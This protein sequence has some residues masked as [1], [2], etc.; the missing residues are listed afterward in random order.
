LTL[1][2]TFNTSEICGFFGRGRNVSEGFNPFIDGICGIG[3]HNISGKRVLMRVE[4]AC[5]KINKR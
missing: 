2:A 1:N 3:V 4:T 5:S